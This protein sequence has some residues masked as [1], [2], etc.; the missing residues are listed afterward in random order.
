MR[1]FF[2]SLLAFR[3]PYRDYTI[4]ARSRDGS[5]VR[6]FEVFSRDAYTACRQFDTDPANARWIRVSGAT[7]KNP[8][9]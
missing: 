4:L 6:Q 7:L 2:R 5:W 9:L 8:L 3:A 1:N